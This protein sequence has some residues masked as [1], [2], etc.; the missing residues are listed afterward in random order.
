MRILICCHMELRRASLNTQ[1][2]SL[3]VKTSAG[4]GLLI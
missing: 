1:H 3:E 4:I 2:A